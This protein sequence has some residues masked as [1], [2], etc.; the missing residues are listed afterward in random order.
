[1]TGHPDET[2]ERWAQRVADDLVALD[3]SDWLTFSVH[4][5]STAAATYAAQQAPRKRRRP[6]APSAST[7]APADVFV[8][9]RRLEGVLALECIADTEFEGLTDLSPQQQ[10]AIVSLGWEQD[11]EDPDDSR[12]FAADAAAQAADLL[13]RTLRDVVGAASPSQVDVR[14]RDAV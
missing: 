2:W 4:V 1:M 9:A 6:F 12:T 11:G 8:Q 5:E 3:E 13:S 7:P 14:R 10:A